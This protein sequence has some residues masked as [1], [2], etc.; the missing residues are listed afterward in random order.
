MENSILL[1]LSLILLISSP[2]LIWL[3]TPAKGHLRSVIAGAKIVAAMGWWLFLAVFIYFNSKILLSDPSDRLF[4]ALII[5]FVGC[6]PLLFWLGNP[7]Q[8]VLSDII[9]GFKAVSSAAWALLLG[10]VVYL[11]FIFSPLDFVQDQIVSQQDSPDSAYTVAVVNRFGGATVS[12]NTLV[13]IRPKGESIDTKH[14]Q[15]LFQM[16]GIKRVNLAWAGANQLTIQ[17]VD[18]EVYQQMPT[19]RNVVIT[20]AIQ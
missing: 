6:S 16:D 13:V 18:G 8:S 7:T 20:Y 14:D 5:L 19:W 2:I 15:V 12:N 10:I 11:G 3:K 9:T 1:A 17:H 4:L